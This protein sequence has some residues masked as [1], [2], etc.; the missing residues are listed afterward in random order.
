MFTE[1]KHFTAWY[2]M[3]PIHSSPSED[4]WE[5]P[6]N[7]SSSVL[8]ILEQEQ[9]DGRFLS[10]V[11]DDH[12]GENIY[13]EPSLP[14]TVSQRSMA[15]SIQRDESRNDTDSSTRVQQ[16]KQILVLGDATNTVRS[17]VS[18]SNAGRRVRRSNFN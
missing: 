17:K 10:P 6:T 5:I 4:M 1:Q 15:V 12:P 13:T 11:Y 7:T 3:Y 14:I 8:E 2:P 9:Q 16:E 18:P